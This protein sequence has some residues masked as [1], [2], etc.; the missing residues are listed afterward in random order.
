M[1]VPG[2][3]VVTSTVVWRAVFPAIAESVTWFAA[4]IRSFDRST[5]RRPLKAVRTVDP[6]VFGELGLRTLARLPVP[7][8]SGRVDWPA[9]N[10]CAPAI[11]VIIGIRPPGLSGKVRRSEMRPPQP[12]KDSR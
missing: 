10:S 11:D 2:K 4:T 9:V 6:F 7:I 8:A 5:V 1:L 12:V 3:V